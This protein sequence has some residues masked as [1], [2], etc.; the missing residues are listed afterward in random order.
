MEQVWQEI[1]ARSL[2]RPLIFWLPYSGPKPVREHARVA[3]V[4][5]KEE[6]KTTDEKP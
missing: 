6:E 5:S 3:I 1:E 2:L 4:I